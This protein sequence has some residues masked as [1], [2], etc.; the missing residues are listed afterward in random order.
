MNAKY[1]KLAARF[2]PETR[3]ALTPVVSVPFRATLN[4][5]LDRLKDRLLRELLQSTTDPELNP[6]LRRAANE[7]TALAWT[8]PYPLLVLPTLLEEKADAARRYARHQTVVWKR[9]EELAEAA[10]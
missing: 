9:R 2:A 10:V 8:T 5:A 7:A 4:D 6:L 1:R 3:F